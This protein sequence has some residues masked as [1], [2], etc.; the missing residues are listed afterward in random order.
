MEDKLF[1]SM[2]ACGFYERFSHELRT[3]LTGIIGFSEY[4]EH[5]VDEPMMQFAAQV[6]NQGG[7]DVLR[8][9]SAYFDWLRYELEGAPLQ[10]STFN[11]IDVVS[12]TMQRAREFA[13]L[14]SVRLI[15]NCDSGAWGLRVVS[16]LS[17]FKR[18]VDL[19]LQDF[20]STSSRGD[21]IQIEVREDAANNKFDLL[22]VKTCQVESLRLMELY[23][24]FWSEQNG[25]LHEKQEGPGVSAALAKRFLSG[26]HGRINFTD[27]SEKSFSLGIEFPVKLEIQKNYV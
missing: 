23:K 22:L 1:T 6:I 8:M 10:L 15:T 20:I 9:T 24:S 2:Q 3:S 12:D 4:V 27:L 19:I 14:R 16:D 26:I 5:S 25:F 17:C 21:L 7:R 13:N 11:V 18:L